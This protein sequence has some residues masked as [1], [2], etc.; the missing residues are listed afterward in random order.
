MFALPPNNSLL[1]LKTDL[2]MSGKSLENPLV[3]KV[4]GTD[5]APCLVPAQQKQRDAAP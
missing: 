5:A 4:L 1:A 3:L 2:E